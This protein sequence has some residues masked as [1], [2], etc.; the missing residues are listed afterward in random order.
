M[1]STAK[2]Y[3][4]CF[5]AISIITMFLLFSMQKSAQLKLDIANI[6]HSASEKEQEINEIKSDLATAKTA[7]QKMHE[8]ENKISELK[9]H[10]QTK[11]QEQLVLGQQ[12][13]NVQTQSKN[14][15]AEISTLQKQHKKDQQLLT[16]SDA[17]NAVTKEQKEAFAA[18][19]LATH[20]KIAKSEQ[21]LLKAIETLK[22]KDRVMMMCEAN[23]SKA[24]GEM[25][26]MQAGVS[27]EKLNFNL[28]LD[29]LANK[30]N[31]VEELT[32]RLEQV[33]RSN[34]QEK[35]ADSK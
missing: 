11:E 33:E 19:L 30:A 32:Y 3:F 16:E 25:A 27:Y 22:E 24:T 18:T 10:I 31:I 13:I 17:N 7:V 21:A 9:G 2:V 4:G 34:K 14:S 26:R 8:Q 35:N 6:Q 20:A 15:L 23:L 29:E 28:I 1:G 5:I 12:L